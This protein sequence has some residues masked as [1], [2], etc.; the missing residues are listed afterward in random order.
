MS[1]SKVQEIEQ[2]IGELTQQELQELRQWLEQ[3]K[4]PQPIDAR[5]QTDL[6]AGHLDRAVEQALDDE[7]QGRV[8]PL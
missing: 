2:A 8:R 5:I 1:H 4:G 3:Y 6:A 7:K